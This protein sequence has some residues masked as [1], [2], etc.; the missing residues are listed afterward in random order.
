MS[1][2]RDKYK[3]I[4]RRYRMI[5][6]FIWAIKFIEPTSF[7]ADIMLLINIVD[8]YTFMI[9]GEYMW[10]VA[11]NDYYAELC[12]RE[13]NERIKLEKCISEMH[14]RLKLGINLNIKEIL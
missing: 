4:Y 11:L 3:I 6:K 9:Y 1:F 2:Y 13:M 8:S 14:K 5:R 10:L 7:R 12:I